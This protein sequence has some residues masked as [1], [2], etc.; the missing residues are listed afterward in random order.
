MGALTTPSPGEST[1]QDRPS[2][3]SGMTEP[4][5]RAGGPLIRNRYRRTVRQGSVPRDWYRYRSSCRHWPRR[6]NGTPA[7]SKVPRS[8]CEQSRST[9]SRRGALA[10]RMTRRISGSPRPLNAIA[11][12]NLAPLQFRFD[13]HRHSYSVSA[14]ISATL[15]SAEPHS[16]IGASPPARQHPRGNIRQ[17]KLPMVTSTV[18]ASAMSA[19]CW[20]RW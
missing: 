19:W 14:D 15:G 9:G 10:T 3:I 16:R 20:D 7:I 4:E 12:N 11:A 6:T 8:S 1:S 18:L 17:Y 13:R 5:R 2:T